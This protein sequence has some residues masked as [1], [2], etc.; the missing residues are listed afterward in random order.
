MDLMQRF[1]EQAKNSPKVIVYPEGEDERILEAVSIVS[2]EGIAKPVLL[3]KEDVIK[4]TAG[5]R[6]IDIAGIPVIN[7]KESDKIEIY[8]AGYSEK[9]NDITVGVATRMVKKSLFFGAMMVA[10]GD[11]DGMVAGIANARR[12]PQ[13]PPGSGCI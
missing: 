8:A 6:N 10:G 3:G 11:A 13:R 12:V 5:E 2:E 7:P 4:Q 9:K 1:K